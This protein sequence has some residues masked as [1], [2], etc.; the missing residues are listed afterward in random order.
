MKGA[1]ICC[2]A[3]QLLANTLCHAVRIHMSGTLR[4]CVQNVLNTGSVIIVWLILGFGLFQSI[5]PSLVGAEDLFFPEADSMVLLTAVLASTASSIVSGAV[6]GRIDTRAFLI[7]SAVLSGVVFPVVA[8]TV[9]YPEGIF[10][11]ALACAVHRPLCCTCAICWMRCVLC[12]TGQATSCC[13]L[14]H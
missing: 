12:V 3:M 4:T 8:R 1:G 5:G 10:C 14:V 13:C 6:A 9:W 11:R 2:A 7:M